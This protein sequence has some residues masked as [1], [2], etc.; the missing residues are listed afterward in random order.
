MKLIFY[1][2]NIEVSQYLM[3]ECIYTFFGLN[4]TENISSA[5]ELHLC[6]KLK[7]STH[8]NAV[9]MSVRVPGDNH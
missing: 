5:R 2:Y 9:T 1:I 3:L 6:H 4:I 7:I 8:K